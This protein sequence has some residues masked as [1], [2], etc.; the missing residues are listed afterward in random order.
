MIF[1]LAWFFSPGWGDI[2]AANDADPAL[3]QD[4]H[5]YL[6]DP[7]TYPPPLAQKPE[8]MG[9]NHGGEGVAPPTVPE[10]AHGSASGQGVAHPEQVAAA[11]N[12]SC[13]PTGVLLTPPAPPQ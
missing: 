12:P 7:F 1:C 8:M 4:R 2:W 11:S 13:Q 3:G 9:V 5:C 6:G 10:G